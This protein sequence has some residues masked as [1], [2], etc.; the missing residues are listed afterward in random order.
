MNR[1][2]NNLI[3]TLMHIL[4]IFVNLLVCCF[5]SI[6]INF[7]IL[8]NLY[9]YLNKAINPL[10][11]SV[12]TLYFCLPIIAFFVLLIYG[13]IWSKCKNDFRNI[14]FYLFRL[15]P[16]T[17]LLIMIIQCIFYPFEKIYN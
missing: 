3:Y 6:I 15:I 13:I 14:A 7:I 5:S 10:V 2:K 11:I 16:L 9:L 1:K 12:F 8:K 4:L 17:I